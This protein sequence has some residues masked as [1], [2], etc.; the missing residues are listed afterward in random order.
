MKELVDKYAAKLVAALTGEEVLGRQWTMA[1]VLAWGVLAGGVVQLLLHLAPLRRFGF[2]GARRPECDSAEVGSTSP[3]RVLRA[4]IPLALGAAVYQVNVMIDGLMAE[5]M[6]A[7][8]GPT[9]LYYA[10]RIQQFP[11]ALVA[12]AAISSVFP[13]LQAHG[14]LRQL[15]QRVPGNVHRRLRGRQDLRHHPSQRWLQRNQTAPGQVEADQHCPERR[16]IDSLRRLK[17]QAR[18]CS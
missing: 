2:L 1:R 16:R 4:S 7:D 6:L 14:H 11:L 3:W 10:N 8:G 18:S 5:G 15:P 9:A 13:A 12:T 17:I